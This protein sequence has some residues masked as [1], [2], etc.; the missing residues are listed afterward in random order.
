MIPSVADLKEFLTVIDDM[1]R[2]PGNGFIEVHPD[3]EQYLPI[4]TGVIW[5]NR[6]VVD[7]ETIKY[8]WMKM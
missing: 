4:T 7:R 3:F 6:Q 5:T 8:E 2:D 1:T